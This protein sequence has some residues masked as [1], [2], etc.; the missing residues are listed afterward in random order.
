[1]SYKLKYPFRWG[2]DIVNAFV[3][4][5]ARGFKNMAMLCGMVPD[6]LRYDLII[7]L[8]IGKNVKFENVKLVIKTLEDYTV[9]DLKGFSHEDRKLLY[10][11]LVMITQ[12]AALDTEIA[13]ETLDNTRQRKL[14][15]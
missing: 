14:F 12:D 5:Y 1:M 2:R 8:C 13:R 7:C 10:K 6:D 3:E 11:Y 4:K 15:L 9:N